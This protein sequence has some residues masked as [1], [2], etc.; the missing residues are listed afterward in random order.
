MVMLKITC[1]KRVSKR[2][3]QLIARLMF[4]DHEAVEM[5]FCLVCVKWKDM[6][7]ERKINSFSGMRIQGHVIFLG[8]TVVSISIGQMCTLGLLHF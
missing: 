6:L 7:L 3:K 4:K 5:D 1:S 2:E 8:S